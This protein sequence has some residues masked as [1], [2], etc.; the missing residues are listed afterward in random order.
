MCEALLSG[1]KHKMIGIQVFYGRKLILH[2]NGRGS[3]REEVPYAPFDLSTISTGAAEPAFD[4]VDGELPAG[5]YRCR[6]LVNG[7]V[8]RARTFVVS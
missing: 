4:P 3:Y 6:F 5:S 7:N 2:W 8:V 1:V